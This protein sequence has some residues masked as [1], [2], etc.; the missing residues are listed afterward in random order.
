MK[1]VCYRYDD[2]NDDTKDAGDMGAGHEVVALYEI[3][4]ASS[5]EAIDPAEFEIPADLKY[6]GYN[7]PEE[8]L[9]IID[10]I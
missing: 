5:D 10:S 4:P 6:S 9:T 3:I 2:F 8:L 1:T 7:H